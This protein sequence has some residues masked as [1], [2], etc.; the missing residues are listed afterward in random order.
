MSETVLYLKNALFHPLKTGAVLP[1]SERLS[2]RIVDEAHV[3]SAD[4]IVE[5]GPGTGA[6]TQTIIEK[7]S[8][9]ATLVAM[10]INSDFAKRIRKRFPTARVFNACAGDT[11]KCLKSVGITEC[12][13]IVS[14]L[15]WSVFSDALQKKLLGSV[16]E[17]LNP[18]GIFTSFAYTPMHMLPGGRKFKKNLEAVFGKIK[19]TETEWRNVPPAF[20]YRAVK[21]D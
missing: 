7:M 4:V 3:S 13:S 11:L 1:S 14:G 6:L 21:K 17:V 2:N 12:D 20:I 16:Y 9:E 8:P 18:G 15:P 10:E 19:K 5:F